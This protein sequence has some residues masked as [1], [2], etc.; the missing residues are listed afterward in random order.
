MLKNDRM[1]AQMHMREFRFSRF[2]PGWCVGLE[3]LFTQ[4]R[5]VG[6]YKAE[7]NCV[8]RLRSRCHLDSCGGL[9]WPV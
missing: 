9:L 6:M 2:G 7:T 3:D 8:V 1:A 5:S 4:Y